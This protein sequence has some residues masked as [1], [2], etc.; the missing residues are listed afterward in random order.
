MIHFQR[1][2]LSNGLRVLVHE[3]PTTPIVAV[4]V[5]YRVGSRDEHPDH[6]GMAHLMEHYMFTG[7]PNAPDYDGVLQKIGAYN[8]AYTSQDLTNYYIV[9]PAGNLETALWLE[10]DRMLT[11]CFE[12]E[13]LDVQKHVVIEE[14]KENYLNRPYGDLMMLFYGMAYKKHPYQWLPIGKK[15]EHI[16]EVD[17]M[18]IKEFR[19]RFYRP[20]NAVLVVAGNVKAAEVFRLAEKWFGDIPAGAAKE[21]V[22]PHE[23]VQ[24]AAR[25]LEVRRDV[26]TPVL[27]KG[28]PMCDRLHPDYHTYDLISDMFG[29]G[30]SAYLYQELVTKR[31]LFSTIS[32]S[33]TGTA[34]NGCFL[35]SG[36]PNEGV[37]LKEADQALTEFLYNFQFPDT[38]PHDL[39]KVQNR[40]ESVL[41]SNEIKVDDRATTL[42]IGEVTSE[43]EYFTCERDHYF[44]ITEEKVQRVARD[45]FKEEKSNTLY[46]DVLDR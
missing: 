22:Y 24:T 39:Q 5:T 4:N 38:L 45:L 30:Q 29:T 19:S 1:T 37:T 32:A 11:L 15:T 28:W 34:D 25:F 33:I 31:K 26:P 7:S 2:I 8:N 27:M 23:E 41:L 20:D 36:Y 21:R 6:T 43:A 35:I 3:D 9:L 46:Y 40:A 42:A 44:A 18:M 10:S 13:T 14:F 17:M 12:Q 16:A